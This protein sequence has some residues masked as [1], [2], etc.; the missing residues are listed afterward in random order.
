MG[1]EESP[2]KI[3]LRQGIAAVR[4][5]RVEQAQRLLSQVLD[6]DADSERA[7]LWMSAV[8]HGEDRLECLKSVLAINPFN[9]H[10]RPGLDA[11]LGDS[12]GRFARKRSSQAKAGRGTSWRLS[13]TRS[14]ADMAWSCGGHGKVPPTPRSSSHRN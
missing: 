2:V 11:L 7:W 9:E 14:R 1:V 6:L 5:G 13:R 3:L 4:A 8:R 10:A 12:C